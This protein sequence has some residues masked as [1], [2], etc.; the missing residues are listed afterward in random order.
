MGGDK[1]N[2]KIAQEGSMHAHNDF[3]TSELKFS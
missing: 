3:H 1:E 2:I